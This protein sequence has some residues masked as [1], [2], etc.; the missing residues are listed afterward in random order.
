[1]NHKEPVGLKSGKILDPCCS[2]RMWWFDRDHPDVVYGDRRCE[3]ITV[4][5]RSHGKQDGTRTLRVDPDVILDFR[6]LPYEDDTFY[7]VAFDPPHL[8]RAG[9]RS[10]MAAKYGK[11]GPDWREDLKKGFEECLR[12]LKP[13]GTLVFKWNETH[14]KIREV[15][16]CAPIPPLFGNTSGKQSGTHWIVFMKPEKEYETCSADKPQDV[17]AGVPG[18]GDGTDHTGYHK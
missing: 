5:D 14:V 17:R 6:E 12:V 4:T 9:K 8:I 11:L 10:W 3:T 15:L 13:N 7:L 18:H 16:E 2:S 1:M